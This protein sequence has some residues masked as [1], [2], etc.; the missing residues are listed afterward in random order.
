M[1][2][3]E[4]CGS[5]SW[6]VRYRRPDGTTDSVSGFP[7]K[8]TAQDHADDIASD[9]RRGTWLDP[10]GGRTTLAVWSTDWLAALDV[11]PRT[12]D[13]YRSILR[14]HI[15][16]RWGATALADISNPDA[17]RW[18]HQ[19]NATGLAPTTVESI[20]KLLSLIL[21]DAA[22][23]RRIAANPLRPHRRGRRRP[24]ARRTEVIW[25]QPAEALHVAD[26]IAACYGPEGALLVVTAAWSG[27]RWG[28][29]VGLQ[30]PNLRL[31][32]DDTGY[33]AIDPDIG[34]LHESCS[35]RLWLG[36][37]KTT[38][39]ARIIALPPFLVRLLRAH[40]EHH[41]HRHV[42]TTPNGD[43][44]RRSN[45]A[46]RAMR[47]A[48][49]GRHATTTV[50]GLHTVKY[51]L[52]FKGLRHSHKTWMIADA[53]PD[54][55]QSRRLGH[56]LSDKVQQAYSHVA[57]EVENRL[58]EHLQRRWDSAVCLTAAGCDTT[59]RDPALS[60]RGGAPCNG[61]TRR[62]PY[63]LSLPTAYVSRYVSRMP[64]QRTQACDRSG[65][66]VGEQP[67][68]AGEARGERICP[69][70]PRTGPS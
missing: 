20:M 4:Q 45:F 3:I 2:W 14:I 19:L 42:F 46:R 56:V 22:E 29:L 18:A 59:W 8:R 36:P 26:Q 62:C 24:V 47:P 38:E 57:S 9:Q 23:D 7:T 15:L 61:S 32:D 53:I 44:H 66:Y 49:D 25:A 16:P 52:T 58:L 54:I 55:A 5:H 10:M 39:S 51:G 63:L 65:S 17:H 64:Y 68:L 50:R 48:A 69:G 67:S 30:R 21:T 41:D 31:F 33:I 34:A 37:P 60:L 28:E 12:E 13:N 6:R 35:G 11:D 1:P 40:L 27:A 43:L 70:P